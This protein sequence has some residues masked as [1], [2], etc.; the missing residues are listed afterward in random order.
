VAL[1]EQ[2]VLQDLLEQLD[3]KVLLEWE[4]LVLP[5]HWE[6]QVHKVLQALALLVLPEQLALP[7]RREI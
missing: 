7:D 5:D 4:Q 2:L 3:H 6:Q 1:R